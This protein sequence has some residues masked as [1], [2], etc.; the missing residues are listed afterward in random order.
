MTL[1]SKQRAS[2]RGQ[3]H[4]LPVMVHIGH[5]GVTEAVR[6]TL[7]DMLR[8]QELVKVQFAKTFEGKPKHVVND[9]ASQVSADVVQVIGRTATLYRENPELHK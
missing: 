7:D 1:T 5:Q 8:T 6:Q 9:V 4:H 3:A 2:L